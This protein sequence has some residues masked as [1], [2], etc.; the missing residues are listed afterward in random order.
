VGSFSKTNPPKIHDFPCHFYLPRN[1]LTPVFQA[2]IG[3][4]VSQ[5]RIRAP[6]SPPKDSIIS[7]G[8][9]APSRPPKPCRRRILSIA[10]RPLSISVHI[11]WGL[12]NDA[13]YTPPATRC[14]EKL[15]I[16]DIQT[17]AAA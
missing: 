2:K 13:D 4:F 11:T 3:G 16:N 9:V 1:H 6:L 14:P 8:Y 7:Q 15:F 5:K 10:L 12:F 17:K